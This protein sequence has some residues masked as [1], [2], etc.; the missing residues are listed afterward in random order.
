VT[1]PNI[2]MVIPDGQGHYLGCYGSGVRTP[3]I[4]RL[5]AAGVLHGDIPDP[6]GDLPRREPV[7][8]TPPLGPS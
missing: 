5:A 1:A 2:I 8:I 7:G 3:Q 4:D 6:L